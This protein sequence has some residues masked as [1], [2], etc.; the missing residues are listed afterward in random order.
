[1]CA[2]GLDYGGD[3]VECYGYGDEGEAEEAGYLDLFCP[4]QL[5][6]PNNREWKHHQNEIGEDISDGGGNELHKTLST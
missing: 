3:A 5:R 2:A 1:M 4:S 6:T